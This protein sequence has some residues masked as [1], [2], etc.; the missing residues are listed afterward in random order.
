MGALCDERRRPEKAGERAREKPEKEETKAVIVELWEVAIGRWREGDLMVAVWSEGGG[1]DRWEWFLYQRSRVRGDVDGR[2]AEMGR[3]AWE[4]EFAPP[5]GGWAEDLD[6]LSPLRP[7]GASR[8]NLAALPRHP[9]LTVANDC[10]SGVRTWK[11]RQIFIRVTI[12]F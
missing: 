12:V 2:A 8:I 5:D 3:A 6:P 10:Q 11:H 4:V 9:R 1:G 7:I